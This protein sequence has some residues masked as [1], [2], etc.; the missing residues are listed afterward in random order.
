EGRAGAGDAER[1]QWSPEKKGY[2]RQIGVD[3]LVVMAEPIGQPPA[4]KHPRDAAKKK[5][6]AE[7]LRSLDKAELEA[8]LKQAGQPECDAISEHRGQRCSERHQPER[9]FAS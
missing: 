2:T 9:P 6:C 3:R 7:E 8:A 1:K 4:G 5:Q